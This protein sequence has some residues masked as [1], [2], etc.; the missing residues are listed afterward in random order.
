MQRCS[1]HVL[2]AAETGDRYIATAP[3]LYI[4]VPCMLWF[5]TKIISFVPN[6][7]NVEKAL[8]GEGTRES[9]KSR[10]SR[11]TRSIIGDIVFVPNGTNGE[12]VL[13][14]R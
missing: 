3:K 2:R 13:S 11:E 14:V 7:T 4:A 6:R 1:T 8:S 10:E 5:F 9:R 12:I